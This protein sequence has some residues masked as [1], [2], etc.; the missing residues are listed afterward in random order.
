MVAVSFQTGTFQSSLLI[1]DSISMSKVINN[2]YLVLPSVHHRRI[3]R[4]DPRDINITPETFVTT[5]GVLRGITSE[6]MPPGWVGFI[7]Y[8][9]LK[10]EVS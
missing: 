10:Y 6:S 1:L 8:S 9:L 2:D 5:T 4:L 3:E 7:R